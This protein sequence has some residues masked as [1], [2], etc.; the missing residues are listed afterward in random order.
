LSS[1]NEGGPAAQAGLKMGDQL[2]RVGTQTIQKSSQV[3]DVLRKKSPG[4][5][6]KVRLLRKGQALELN[7]KL[8][9]RP[10]G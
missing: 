3:L 5:S 2:D 10:S 9:T 7:V 1:V 6:I 8:G 4:Q